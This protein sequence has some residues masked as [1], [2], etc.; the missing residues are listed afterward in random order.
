MQLLR[1]ETVFIHTVGLKKELLKKFFKI[2][3][4]FSLQQNLL[5]YTL[6]LWIHVFMNLWISWDVAILQGQEIKVRH[7]VRSFGNSGGGNMRTMTFKTLLKA[8]EDIQDKSWHLGKSTTQYLCNK[9]VSIIH[10][11]A[12][13]RMVMRYK[14]NI[15]TSSTNKEL[16][17]SHKKNQ[18]KTKATTPWECLSSK[19]K[20]TVT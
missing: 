9:W 8:P 16:T 7:H 5:L 19:G 12:K 18:S 11:H 2:N 10:T 17:V 13:V 20:M 4:I 3:L 6:Q 14:I 1:I 15:K